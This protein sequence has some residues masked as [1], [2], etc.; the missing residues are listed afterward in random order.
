[1]KGRTPFHGKTE[2]PAGYVELI[3][4]LMRLIVQ[5]CGEQPGLPDLRWLDPGTTRFIGPLQGEAVRYLAD[6]PDAFRL[7]EWLDVQ[8]D[9]KGSLVQLTIALRM[10]GHLPGGPEPESVLES[11]AFTE[12]ESFAY[13]KGETTQIVASP[14]GHCGCLLENASSAAGDSPD[15]GCFSVCVRCGG[16][17]QFDENLRLARVDEAALEALPPEARSHLLEMGD[18]LR[19]ARMGAKPSKDVQA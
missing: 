12:L 7:V 1:M 19:A 9:R 16:I 10:L 18:L 6:S 5:W 4:T 17:N 8:T 13:A 3:K 2:P 14:C 15:P 11:K